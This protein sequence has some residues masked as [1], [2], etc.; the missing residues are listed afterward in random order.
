[1]PRTVSARSRLSDISEDDTAKKGLVVQPKKRLLAS[2]FPQWEVSQ[3]PTQLSRAIAKVEHHEF[4]KKQLYKMEEIRNKD[5][6]FDITTGTKKTKRS[7]GRLGLDQLPIA[8]IADV[9]NH[10]VLHDL[11]SFIR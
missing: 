2:L 9:N 7:I 4:I 3:Y 1:M 5:D 10:G 11:F 8:E 6:A